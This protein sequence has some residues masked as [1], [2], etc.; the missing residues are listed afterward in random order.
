MATATVGP[1]PAPALRDRILET[2]RAKPQNVVALEERRRSRLVPVLGVAVAVAACAALG[3]GLWGA[4]ASSDLD[5]ARSALASERAA[6]AVLA[7]PVSEAALTGASGRL[8]VGKDG[9][10]VLVVSDVPPVPAGKRTALG[11]RRRPPGTGRPLRPG[12]GD[13]RDPA[14]SKRRERL[15]RRGD[16]GGRRR[17]RRTD[18]EAG[19][20]VEAR[21][22]FRDA[23]TNPAGPGPTQTRSDRTR[24][25]VRVTDLRPALRELFGFDDFRP[26]QEAVVRA[27][28]GGIDTLAVMPTGAGKSLTYQLAAMLRPSPT[29][30]LSPLI[31]L[32]KDQVDKLPPEI[33]ATATFVNSL[34]RPRRGARR[35]SRRRRGRD[36][37]PLRRAGA[38][39]AASRSS[40]APRDRR[41]P[42]RDRRG[43]LRR[44]VGARLPARLPLHPPRARRARR[45]VGARDDGDRDAGDADAIAEALGRPLEMVRTSVHR[46]NLRYDVERAENAEE[47][48]RGAA[49]PAAASSTRARRSSTRARAD[50]CEEIARTLRGHGIAAEHYHAGL[51]PE[52]RT[53]VQES[54]V[55][56]RTPRA[57]S[58]P[59]RSGWAS[60]RRTCGSWRSSTS[61]TRSRAT[62]RW[63]A[64][65][66][67]TAAERHRALRRATPTQPRFA[68][69]R[70]ATCRPP[71]SSA[72]STA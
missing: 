65:R 2:A 63:S 42:R 10:A 14:R 54:F 12:L 37:A 25:L 56:G 69:S 1:S 43:A 61:R 44:D 6:A 21:L 66:D 17:R 57:S 50:S 32:M 5:E 4:S 71:S 60:T 41:R 7:Q 46:P 64:A 20:R 49:A 59:P 53:R 45:A 30:V 9:Q 47:R 26:G 16:G 35:G 58:R 23:G 48:L 33:A 15:G 29:L 55:A 68:A 31:A 40:D 34:A 51:E 67:G 38:A 28:L 27:A 70:S 8:V 52:E 62:C 13:A 19:D 36:T 24:T 11:D 72:A 22:A 3:L 18:R 39:A